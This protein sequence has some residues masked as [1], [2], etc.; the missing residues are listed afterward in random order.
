MNALEFLNLTI[1]PALAM[2][3]PKYQGRPVEI[4]LLAIALQ[5][6]AL[7]HRKQVGGPARGFWQFER[8]GVAG[9]SRHGA[10]SAKFKDACTAFLYPPTVDD[11]YGVIADN[12]ALACVV[13]RLL[14]YTHAKAIPETG[15]EG[16]AYYEWLWRP[17]KPH[18]ETWAKN[19]AAAV[20]AVSTVGA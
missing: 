9:V 10:S 2:M 13:A 12:D 4:L 16:W 20:D 17:G 14:L 3:G 8:G 15:P 19:W 7:R 5:E 11:V 1:R 6:S 18:P